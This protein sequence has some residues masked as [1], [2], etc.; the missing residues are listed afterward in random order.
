MRTSHGLARLHKLIIDHISIADFTKPLL[1]AHAV[2][3]ATRALRHS[4]PNRQ[5]LAME[6]ASSLSALSEY[7]VDAIIALADQSL[8]DV[9]VFDDAISSFTPWQNLI[10]GGIIVNI[11][12][13]LRQESASARM[14]ALEALLKFSKYCT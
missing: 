13:R 14:L 7:K 4:E 8:S 5:F 10:A 9:T 12:E 1:D 2:G 11:L 3:H 6:M